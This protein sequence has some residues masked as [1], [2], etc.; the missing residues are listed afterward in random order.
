M[1]SQT[2]LSPMCLPLLKFS[3]ATDAAAELSAFSWTHVHNSNLLVVFDPVNDSKMKVLQ[4]NLLL[5]HVDLKQKANEASQAIEMARRSGIELRDDQLAMTVIVRSPLLAIRYNMLETNQKRRL[6]LKFCNETDFLQA[7]HVVEAMGCRIT[8]SVP[9]KTATQAP[10]N[11]EK[12]HPPLAKQQTMARPD[13]ALLKPFVPP[14]VH[15][16]TPQMPSQVTPSGVYPSTTS[17]DMPIGNGFAGHSC[18]QINHSGHMQRSYTTG[19]Q[20]LQSDLGITHLPQTLT[21]TPTYNLTAQPSTQENVLEQSQYRP[22]D[23]VT[24]Q[25]HPT[26]NPLSNCTTGHD[27]VLSEADRTPSQH[28]EPVEIQRPSTTSVL[29]KS[30][31]LQSLPPKRDLPWA[32]SRSSGGSSSRPSTSTLELPPLP[33]PTFAANTAPFQSLSASR[34]NP[35]SAAF[36]HDPSRPLSSSIPA[37]SHVPR[38]RTSLADI[39]NRLPFP[40]LT[41]SPSKLSESHPIAMTNHESKGNSISCPDMSSTVESNNDAERTASNND[42]CGTL[43]DAEQQN[44]GNVFATLVN[45]MS[46]TDTPNMAQYAAQSVEDR[47]IMISNWMVRHIGDDNFVTLC[48][49]VASTWQRVGLGLEP[50]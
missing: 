48:E 20:H 38:P 3:Y 35:K 12:A 44:D 29:E 23:S 50:L 21:R 7:L 15:S 45:Q 10:G 31:R 46:A 4:G 17:A 14:Q 36:D 16:S 11:A 41:N 47:R 5:E 43:R 28:R 2:P 8:Q 18:S 37:V 49:D 9:L 25:P 42:R 24:S 19:S 32:K 40:S 1:A 6:Q 34:N 27:A 22:S 26:L 30:G 39:T 33:A 13:T